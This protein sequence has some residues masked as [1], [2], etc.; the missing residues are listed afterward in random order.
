MSPAIEESPRETAG[1]TAVGALADRADERTNDLFA[2]LVQTHEKH[3]WCI[4]E[5]LGS[6]DGLVS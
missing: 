3:A 1:P 5:F 6:G 4:E 2:T